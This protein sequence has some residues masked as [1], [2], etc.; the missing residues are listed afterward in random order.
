MPCQIYPANDANHF[1]GP[2][3]KGQSYME[4]ACMCIL[5]IHSAS[6]CPALQ[7]E[8]LPLHKI[9]AN[10][11]GTGMAEKQAFLATR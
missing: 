11:T 10:Y 6:T 2:L 5:G 8:S 4:S 9:L 1:R 3:V 7:L